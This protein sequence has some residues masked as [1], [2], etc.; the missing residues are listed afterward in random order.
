M[1]VVQAVVSGEWSMICEMFTNLTLIVGVLS[2]YNQVGH[3]V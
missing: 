3:K 2:L 1:R